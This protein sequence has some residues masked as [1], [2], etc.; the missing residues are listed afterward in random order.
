MHKGKIT[1]ESDGET[2]TRFLLTLPLL[3]LETD[4]TFTHRAETLPE[5]GEAKPATKIPAENTAGDRVLVVD[6]DADIRA[7]ICKTL[8][9]HFRVTEAG[10]G[11]EALAAIEEEVPKVVVSD[12]MMPEMDGVALLKAL[13]A[14]P[15]TKHVPF[16]LLSG[17]GTDK[18]AIEAMESGA[19]AYLDKPFHP[20]H[21]LARI[22]RLLERDEEVIAYSRSAQAAIGKFA[23]KE[24]K[25][26]DRELLKRITEVIVS[27]LDDESLTG[28]AV[29]ESVAISE[30]QLYRKLKTLAGMTPTEYIRNLRLERSAELL[31]SSN[32]TVQEIMYACGFVT[33]TYFF[34]EFAKRY[35]MS[36]GAYR[37][38]SAQKQ[39]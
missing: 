14:D 36:P 7:F 15:R 5:A 23:G 6:D 30:M 12:L 17:K 13:R 39:R 2:Y 28:A 9:P 31:R 21:L 1:L 38:E 4:E 27:R 34:R 20:G 18:T 22:H 8:E 11:R 33:K 25:K 16:I 29:A 10:N 32:K 35:G 26:A 19:D 37:Q 24:M 3:P